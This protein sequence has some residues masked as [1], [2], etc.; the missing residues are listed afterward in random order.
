ML[1]R[2]DLSEAMSDARTVLAS[3]EFGFG[4]GG[5]LPR[6]ILAECLIEQ[7]QIEQAR[8]VL[9]NA[10]PQTPAEDA[11]RSHLNCAQGRILMLEGRAPQALELFVEA[12]R[13]VERTGYINPAVLPW[14]ARAAARRTRA[15]VL[16][17]RVPSLRSPCTWLG[18]PTPRWR[19]P[20]P[21]ASVP[22]SWSPR[23]R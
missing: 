8:T 4:M 19:S 11:T 20:T 17:K 7:G 21:S 15:A 6:A 5:V 22:R 23:M 18:G 10:R 2:G 16:A 3:L 14:R 9:A 13:I 12:G 1:A